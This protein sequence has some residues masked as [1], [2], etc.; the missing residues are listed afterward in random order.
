MPRRARRPDA[1]SL[2]D[3]LAAAELIVVTGKG[4]V[5]KSAVAGALARLASRRARRVL[6]LETDPRESLHQYLAV[7]PSG[8]EIVAVG[9]R[10]LLQNLRPSAV[11]D[12][13]VREQLRLDALSRRVLASPV[14]RHFADAA[15]GLKEI[16]VLGHAFR[17]VRGLARRGAPRVDLVVLDAPATGHGVSLLAAPSLAAE[18][19]RGGPFGRMA[20][21]LSRFVADRESCA[22]VT[23]ALA[24][25]M[26]VEEALD[27][28]RMLRERLHRQADL[29]VVNGLLPPLDGADGRS[30]PED[31]LVALYR[32]RRELAAQ[33]LVRLRRGWR[34]PSVD[35]ALLPLDRGP[36]LLDAI[37]DSLAA[38]LDRPIAPEPA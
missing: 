33:Q 35:L 14:Y 8:G 19:I 16:A 34:G 24:E 18:V 2:L 27:L 12:E 7:P 25:E 3:R 4:G 13:L 20:A 36:E 5:G 6:L 30:D 11:L 26:P 17:L 38:Q 31:P 37:S 32:R 9:S 22:I 23:V 10:L 1:K 15:P 29:L 21:E 28:Q